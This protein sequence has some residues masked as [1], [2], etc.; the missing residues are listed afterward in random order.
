VSQAHVHI[1]YI[2]S[3]Y[4]TNNKHDY[5][6]KTYIKPF[7]KRFQIAPTLMLVGSNEVGISSTPISVDQSEGRSHGQNF[8]DDEEDE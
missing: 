1:N 3:N 6:M 2:E 8:W 5:T 7:V 4:P